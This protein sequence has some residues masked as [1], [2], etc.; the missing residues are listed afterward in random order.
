M[1]KELQNGETIDF[2]GGPYARRNQ[3]MIPAVIVM[4]NEEG[5]FP[6]R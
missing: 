2:Y 1:F 4:E 3:G 5:N 6:H